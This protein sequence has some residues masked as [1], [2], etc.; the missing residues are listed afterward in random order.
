MKKNKVIRLTENDLVNIIKKI[1]LEG[2]TLPEPPE[3]ETRT[4]EAIRK[5]IEN[6][7]GAE[8][9]MFNASGADRYKGTK[10]IFK[11]YETYKIK[12]V[13]MPMYKGGV[14]VAF[15]VE[16]VSGADTAEIT[17]ST[18]LF[19][20][21]FTKDSKHPSLPIQFRW[22]CVSY[23]EKGL[24]GKGTDLKRYGG[25]KEDFINTELAREILKRPFCGKGPGKEKLPDITKKDFRGN[26]LTK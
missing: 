22:D 15:T 2:P 24:G 20:G 14:T 16:P 9:V 18:G 7:K 21:A 25:F 4:A 23:F 26:P 10:Q 6:I 13:W 5:Q 11:S 19:K 1:L 3:A 12:D 17:G 8:I